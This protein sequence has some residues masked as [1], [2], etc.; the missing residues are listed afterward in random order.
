MSVHFSDLKHSELAGGVLED[1]VDA[2]SHMEPVTPIVI[3]NLAIVL[4]YSNDES[5]LLIESIKLF[6][7]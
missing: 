3:S 6:N 2:V 7:P 1:T 4:L 5:H